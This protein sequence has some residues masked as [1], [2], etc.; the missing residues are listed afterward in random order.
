MNIPRDLRYTPSH[1]WVRVKGEVATVGV[2]DYAQQQLS[3]LTFVELPEP[4]DE[5]SVSD[6]VGV[7]ES[8]KAA[9]DLYAPVSGRIL[10][11]N[12]RVVDQPEIVN[13]D[14]YGEGWLFKV[15]LSN[16][17]DLGELLDADQYEERVPEED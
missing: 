15:S 9:S 13:S 11:V 7:I 14:P 12:R 17:D 8:V 1:E 16:P 3:D 4:G 6:E 2:T 10:E 5:V